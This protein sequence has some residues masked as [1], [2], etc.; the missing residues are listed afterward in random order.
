MG[1]TTYSG[2]IQAGKKT[3]AA[4]TT[5]VGTTV[6]QQ[7]C[8]VV[9]NTSGAQAVVFPANA[10]VQNFNLIVRSNASADTVAV[11]IGNGDDVDY[12]GQINASGAGLY[13]IADYS[14][15][16]ASFFDVGASSMQV[17]VDVTALASGVPAGFD[18][19]LRATYIQR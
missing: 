7:E 19:I 3:G 14:V 5:T 9:G 4:G 10:E 12:F 15:S 16:A 18:A 1:T 13:D 2:P 8:T 11:R 6:L 17:Y